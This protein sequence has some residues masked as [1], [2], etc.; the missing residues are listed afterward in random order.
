MIIFK[1]GSDE[2]V[3]FWRFV[4]KTLTTL[5]LSNKER[6]ICDFYTPDYVHYSSSVRMV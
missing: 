6:R 1:A 5:N 4:R 2:H 3:V